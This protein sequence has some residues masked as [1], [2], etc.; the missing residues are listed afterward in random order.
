MQGYGYQM[1]ICRPACFRADGARGQYIIVC[2]EKNAVI[3]ITSDV[4]NLQGEL[5]LVWE[6]ILPV[7]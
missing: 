1:W 7:L 6:N 5:N 2:P 3:A 4:E